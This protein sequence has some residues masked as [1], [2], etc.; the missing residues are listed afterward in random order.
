[1]PYAAYCR[2]RFKKMQAQ[3]EMLGA[4]NMSVRGFAD[5]KLMERFA[6]E[7]PEILQLVQDTLTPRDFEAFKAYLFEA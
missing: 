3:V 4:E 5:W 1:M 2:D 7:T 6:L